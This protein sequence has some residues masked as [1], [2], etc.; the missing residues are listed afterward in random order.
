VSASCDTHGSCGLLERNHGDS[1]PAWQPRRVGPGFEWLE[2]DR[3]VLVE[4]SLRGRE[5]RVNIRVSRSIAV[6]LLHEDGRRV[7]DMVALY[8]DS[9]RQDVTATDNTIGDREVVVWNTHVRK[10]LRGNGLCA[11]MTWC[12]FRE[13]LLAQSPASYRIRAAHPCRYNSEHDAFDTLGMSVLA[14]RLGFSSELDLASL[15]SRDN[16]AGIEAV[17]GDDS[18]PPAVRFTLRHG[19]SPLTVLVLSP[20]TMR[21]VLDVRVYEGLRDNDC[22]IHHWLREGLLVALNHNWVL[23][24]AQVG[25]FADSLAADSDEARVFRQGIRGVDDKHLRARCS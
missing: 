11:V 10:D 19:P 12:L 25:R 24:T 7:G 3:I 6:I 23:R 17:N 21:P 20:D 2:H 1:S 13:L 15:L 9:G 14:A 16:I 18:R 4:G 8:R 22:L 5:F